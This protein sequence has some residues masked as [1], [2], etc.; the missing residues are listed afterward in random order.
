MQT[1]WIKKVPI[2]SIIYYLASVGYLGWNCAMELF[3]S[4][5]VILE[6]SDTLN[7]GISGGETSVR[8][9][10]NLFTKSIR[11]FEEYLLTHILVGSKSLRLVCD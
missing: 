4:I 11:N 2:W 10:K 6:F 7:N 5:Y 3:W 8:I 9:G 1:K